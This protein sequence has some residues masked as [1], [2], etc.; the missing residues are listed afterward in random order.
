MTVSRHSFMNTPNFLFL[1]VALSKHKRNRN[2]W[3]FGGTKEIVDTTESH[4]GCNWFSESWDCL[5]HKHM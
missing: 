5:N 3:R 2:M 4:G 1:G